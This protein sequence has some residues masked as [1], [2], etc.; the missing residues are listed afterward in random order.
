MHGLI[1]I[2]NKNSLNNV[3]SW[4]ALTTANTNYQAGAQMSLTWKCQFY[5]RFKGYL[6]PIRVC[7]HYILSELYCIYVTE[8][9]VCVQG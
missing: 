1:F 5:S 2:G 7:E 4:L 6:L 9:F 3:T 8:V